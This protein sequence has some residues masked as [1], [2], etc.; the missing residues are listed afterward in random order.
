[1]RA[2]GSTIGVRMTPEAT[3]AASTTTRGAAMQLTSPAFAHG[4]MIRDRYTCD[5]ADVPPETGKL[6][7]TYAR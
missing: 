6:M 5:G 7:G 3:P 4:G 1:M 2:P